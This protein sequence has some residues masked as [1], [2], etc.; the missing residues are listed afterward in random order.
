MTHAVEASAAYKGGSQSAH[1]LL[2]KR[3]MDVRGRCGGAHLNCSKACP[4]TA[5]WDKG[6]TGLT[7]PTA[8]LRKICGR[9]FAG[10]R[11]IRHC[12]GLFERAAEACKHTGLTR[13]RAPSHDEAAHLPSHGC[14]SGLAR[15]VGSWSS[16][17]PAVLSSSPEIPGEMPQIPVSVLSRSHRERP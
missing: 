11:G 13:P 9:D 5:T 16:A 15:R 6:G 17:Q 3:A 1:Y 7:N 12:K 8:V 10:L 4:Y 2:A 14:S